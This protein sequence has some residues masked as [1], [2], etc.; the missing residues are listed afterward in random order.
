MHTSDDRNNR[1]NHIE[2]FWE[3]YFSILN[4]YGIKQSAHP[5]YRKHIQ[6]FIDQHPHIRLRTHNSE[7][8]T[9]WCTALS[10][11][12]R[13]PLWL[14]K[15]KIDALRMLFSFLLKQN[16]A[17]DFDWEYWM[18]DAPVLGNNHP[19][20]YRTYESGNAGA[21]QKGNSFGR[22]H[23]E[24]YK[25]FIAA[26]R[27]ADLAVNTERSYLGWI[28][29]FLRFHNGA[30]PKVNPE[31]EVASFLEYLAVKRKVEPTPL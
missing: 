25:R 8:L 14:Y 5:W 30:F 1:K 10:K 13:I 22:K 4:R 27:M 15:Q 20:L 23:P 3:H 21:D 7:S 2:Q 16:W 26:I 6:Q 18:A 12:T 11:D 19:T 9:L 28:N 24:I 29:R 31:A 17:S